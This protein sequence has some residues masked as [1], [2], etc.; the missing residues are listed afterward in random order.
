[1]NG[2]NTDERLSYSVCDL[3]LPLKVELEDKYEVILDKGT[4]DA[5]LP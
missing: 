4:L 3:L 5:M 2:K 1:M